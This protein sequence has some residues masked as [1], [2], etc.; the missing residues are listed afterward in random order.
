MG[1]IHSIKYGDY[2]E[3]VKELRNIE[4]K[5]KR[6][7]FKA[8]NFPAFT[9]CGTFKGGHAISNLH[10]YNQ[11]VGLDYD[12]VKDTIALKESLSSIDTSH[13][14]FIS[15]GGEGLKV[16]VKVNSDATCHENAF[17]IVNN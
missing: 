17:E 12:N 13:V 1:V 10:S 15:P 7:E 11:I 14:V 6:Q 2:E 8:K 16:L 3:L 9:W 5:K 4:D